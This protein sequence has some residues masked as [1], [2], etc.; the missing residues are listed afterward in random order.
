M[1]TIEYKA[2]TS[3]KW[4]YLVSFTTWKQHCSKTFELA[5]RNTL[6]L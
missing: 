3:E 4:K 2:P 6:F 1:I 5:A